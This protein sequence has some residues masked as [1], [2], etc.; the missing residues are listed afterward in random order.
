[1]RMSCK[2][3]KVRG[4]AIQ[5]RI[6]GLIVGFK[7][8]YLNLFANTFCL[9]TPTVPS[10]HQTLQSAVGSQSRWQSDAEDLWF[11]QCKIHDGRILEERQLRL[12]LFSVL[13]GAGVD[14]WGR[15]VWLQG[16]F[17]GCCLCIGRNDFGSVKFMTHIYCTWVVFCTYL[18]KIYL[19]CV[20]IESI[21]F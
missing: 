12:R 13:Q 8:Q 2:F 15:K 1:M 6:E 11:R 14:S 16:R 5:N 18:A 3:V 17:V 19:K 10:W 21:I 20:K 9:R 7:V 4:K